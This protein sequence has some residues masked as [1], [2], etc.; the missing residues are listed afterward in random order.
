MSGGPKAYLCYSEADE[1]KVR[2]L[3][4]RL[5]NYF[6]PAAL[7]GRGPARLGRFIPDSSSARL[8]DTARQMAAVDWLIVFSSPNSFTSE[9][10]NAEVDTYLVS[11]PVG[12]FLLVVL[13]G[14]PMQVMPP[15]LR[16]RQPVTADLRAAADGA[17]LGFLKLV[18]AL[19]EVNVGA[20]R[21]Q[22]AAGSRARAAIGGALC[23]GFTAIAAAGSVATIAAVRERDQ[24]TAMTRQAIQTAI[25]IAARADST[26]AD[27]LAHAEEQF[28]RLFASG[29]NS[30][31]LMR[32]R[33]QALV[34]FAELHERRGD[35]A[36]ARA[37]ALAAIEAL[38]ESER[39]SQEFARAAL[40]VSRAENAAGRGAEALDFANRA[41]VAARAVASADDAARAPL[42][43]ALNWL[44][45]LH[46]Q[47][48]K[49]AQA[50]PLF[51]EAA[52]ILLAL[53]ESTPGD[54]AASAAALAAFEQLGDAQSATGDHNGAK[55][56][57]ERTVGLLRA[58]SA[59][60]AADVVALASALA[61]LSQ[62]LRAGGDNEAAR[63]PA[64]ESLTL[65]RRLSAAAPTDA[66]LRDAVAARVILTAQI[67]ASLGGADT[68]LMDEAVSAA[69]ARTLARPG[70]LSA[71]ITLAEMLAANGGRLERARNFEDARAAWREAAVV[72]RR[73][74]A[75][76][77]T[78]LSHAT[79]LA[80]ALEQIAAISVR[81][82][83]QNETLAAYSEA[84]RVRRSIVTASSNDNPTRAA[85]AN[86]LHAAGLARVR[87]ENDTAAMAAFDEAARLRAALAQ[88]DP[89]DHAAADLAL[90]S[91]R[92][93]MRLQT[94]ANAN[95]GLRRSLTVQRDLLTQ[96]AQANPNEARYSAALRRT[97]AA[98]EAQEQAQQ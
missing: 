20:L 78:D 12:R 84:I 19:I 30:P 64:E 24:A 89:A 47:A 22:Q 59:G 34:Q 95:T 15:R 68:A 79:H 50:L 51:A 7:R 16:A 31:A 90:D 29:Q 44:G 14:E 72:Q 87:A 71:Q 58:Q 83:D 5:R 25:E 35:S 77:E 66:D 75:V 52:P 28:D 18:S 55:A 27:S 38:P 21:D 65:A 36:R 93:L 13:E 32:Q 1:A 57:Y 9:R 69:R 74:R 48:S 4:Q 67:Q 56:S 53:H 80:A 61:K 91:L 82:G 92:Q 86:L 97:A 76:A 6:V 11:N 60:E 41:L 46:A 23:A 70:D 33:A 88:E 8:G 43:D 85:L 81:L 10:V 37:R 45:G 39:N 26:D 73:L 94:Q 2:G 3:R 54:Q 49:P 96:L 17:E 98:L 63:A 42:A 62:A 40:L